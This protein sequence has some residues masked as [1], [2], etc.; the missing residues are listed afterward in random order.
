MREMEADYSGVV[1]E[2]GDVI[3]LPGADYLI[4]QNE[5]FSEEDYCTAIQAVQKI[6]KNNPSV[7]GYQWDH[8]NPRIQPEPRGGRGYIEMCAVRKAKRNH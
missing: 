4:F 6:T 1:P 5:P 3:T 8:E 2:G 7:I